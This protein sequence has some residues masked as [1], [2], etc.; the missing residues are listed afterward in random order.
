MR[1]GRLLGVLV[2][3]MGS[4]A[5]SEVYALAVISGEALAVVYVI[6]SIVLDVLRY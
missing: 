3:R 1:L 4:W 5:R 6:G 2:V